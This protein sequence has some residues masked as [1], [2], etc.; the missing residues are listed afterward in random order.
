MA[1]ASSSAKERIHLIGQRGDVPDLLCAADVFAFPSLY[2]G[3][4]GTLIEAMA[5]GCPIV[6]SDAP[7]V[8]E[9]LDHGRLGR[10]APRH[11]PS[12]LA[13]EILHVLKSPQDRERMRRAGLHEFENAYLLES[14]ADATATL[15][16]QI[17]GVIS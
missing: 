4:P 7:S 2:E 3:M 9:V 16:R 8:L 13:Q 17:A 5:M 11:S 12:A 14:V 10:I 1:V 6:G 15:F